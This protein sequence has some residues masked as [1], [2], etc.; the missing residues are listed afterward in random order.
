MATKLRSTAPPTRS[1]QSI[2]ANGVPTIGSSLSNPA[3]G[4]VKLRGAGSR[5]S[6][7]RSRRPGCRGGD[8]VRARECSLD[9]VSTHSECVASAFG[10]YTQADDLR[11]ARRLRPTGCGPSRSRRA[12]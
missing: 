1:A 9:T 2:E 4:A 12:S 6:G 11:A 8:N 5:G 10:M 3:S 7:I